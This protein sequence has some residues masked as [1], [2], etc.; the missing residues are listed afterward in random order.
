MIADVLKGTKLQG[1]DLSNNKL[2]A[3]SIEPIVNAIQ[4]LPTLVKL[5]LYGNNIQAKGFSEFLKVTS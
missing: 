5:S 4:D 3:A 2:N 1:L